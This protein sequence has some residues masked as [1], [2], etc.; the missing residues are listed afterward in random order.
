MQSS[1][2][3]KS[4]KEFTPFDCGAVSEKLRKTNFNLHDGHGEWDDYRS[5]AAVS[6]QPKV[7]KS[8]SV[9]SC[10]VKRVMTACFTVVLK[11]LCHHDFLCCAL[12]SHYQYYPW[13]QCLHGL[14]CCA[15]DHCSVYSEMI[16]HRGT[17]SHALDHKAQEHLYHTNKISVLTILP[18]YF[19]CLCIVTAEKT[20][21]H[22]CKEKKS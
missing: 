22:N 8:I 9:W 18:S 16:C 21:L 12:W 17:I 4:V 20:K 10:A 15:L 6:Y 7:D 11:S 19:W 3:D 2:V 5:I 13:S 14:L 1:F